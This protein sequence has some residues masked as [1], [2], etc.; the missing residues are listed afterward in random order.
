L[1]DSLLSFNTD[2]YPIVVWLF[3][4]AGPMEEFL[5]NVIISDSYAL[6]NEGSS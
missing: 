5:V 2:F 4:K 3:A 6:R 1:A